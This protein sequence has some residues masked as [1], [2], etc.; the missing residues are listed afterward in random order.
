MMIKLKLLESEKVITKNINQAIAEYVNNVLSSKKSVILTRAKSLAVGWVRIQPEIL[1]LQSSSPDS[2]A[3]QFGL[4][5]GSSSS[6]VNSIISAVEQSIEVQFVPFNNNLKRG[7]LEINFQPSTFNN[8]L[9]L[10]EGHTS[11]FGGDLHWLSWLLTAGDLVIVANY[12]YNPQTGIGR[13]GL[14]NMVPGGSFR[15]PPQ[16][17]GDINNNFITRAFIGSQQESQ[18]ATIFKDIL[19]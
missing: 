6:A 2:L 17:S 13:S 4:T 3:G 14:G 18:I 15:V 7:G 9:G 1:S 5:P 19:S 8:L 10:S 12:Q 16:F 11:Y